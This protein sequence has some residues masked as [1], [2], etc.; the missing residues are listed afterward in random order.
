MASIN[1]SL[2]G[3]RIIVTGAARG[4]GKQFAKTLLDHQA[5]VTLLDIL[6]EVSST[7][8]AFAARYEHVS[9]HQVDLRDSKAVQATVD[10]IGKGGGLDILVNNA[11]RTIYGSATDTTP[12]ML[13][14]AFEVNVLTAFNTSVAALPYLRNSDHGR[15]IN[16][17]SEAGQQVVTRF[18]AYGASKAA[19]I[20]MTKH[21]A[22]EHGTD[23]MTVN[24]IA[25][26]PIETELIAQNQNNAVRSELLRLIPANRYG[27]Q[28]EVANAV[29]FLATEGA[30]YV[31]GHV[32]NV[33]GGLQIMS[34]A[35]HNVS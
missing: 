19:L 21:F 10:A 34:A 8:A 15:I 35:L 9:G 20:M 6:D 3:K 26:G 14:E 24:A 4:I 31:N 18:M 29:A 13:S 32:L 25:P 33:D 17:A 7:V 28:S 2:K 22:A 30:S 16:I 12:E 5:D 1:S 27:Q 11:G 23:G